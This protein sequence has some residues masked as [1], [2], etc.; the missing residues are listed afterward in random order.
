MATWVVGFEQ[1]KTKDFLHGIKT[2][3]SYDPDQIQIM[4]VTPHSWTPFFKRAYHGTIIQADQTKWDYKHQ[5][6]TS[7]T[8]FPWQLL[9]CVK[10]TEVILQARPKAIY[11][12][13][14][15]QDKE[16][17]HAMRWYSKV[18]KRVWPYEIIQFIKDS[19]TK[20]ET[21]LKDFW[22]EHDRSEN[23]MKTI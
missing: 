14:F 16:I 13:F 1:E 20:T 15:H 8:M 5:V 21:T 7:K 23:T 12:T 3:L 2:L 22:K 9:A 4:Y 6:L 19:R 17:R 10:L 18:G 11:R